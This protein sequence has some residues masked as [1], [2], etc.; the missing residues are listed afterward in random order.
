MKMREKTIKG[1]KNVFC[2]VHQKENLVVLLKMW[3]LKRNSL[4]KFVIKIIFDW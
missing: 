4:N 2:F 1:T 3:K